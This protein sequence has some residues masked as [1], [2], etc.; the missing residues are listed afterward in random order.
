MLNGWTDSSS[1]HMS[2]DIFKVEILVRE[3]P[4]L[5]IYNENEKAHRIFKNALYKGTQFPCDPFG[6]LQFYQFM[7]HVARVPNQFAEYKVQ[8]SWSSGRKLES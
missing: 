8:S 4:Y 1:P 5:K 7:N 2:C 6:Y 3:S